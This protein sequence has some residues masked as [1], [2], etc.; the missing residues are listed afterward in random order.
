[1][2]VVILVLQN[3]SEDLR[4]RVRGKKPKK[5]DMYKYVYGLNDIP[6]KLTY[7]SPNPRSSECGLIWR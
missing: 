6:S 2:K 3:C 5:L 4:L 1:M 7:G